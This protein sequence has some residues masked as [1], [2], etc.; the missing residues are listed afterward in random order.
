[1]PDN[2]RISAE[3][4]DADKQA[5]L[6]AIAL[7]RSKLPFLISLTPDERTTLP[8]LGEKTLAFE[9]KCRTYMTSHPNL[10]PSFVDAAEVEKDRTLRTPVVEIWREL[11]ALTQAVDDTVLLLGSE[12]YMAD[13]SFYQNSRQAAKMGVADAQTVYNDLKVRFPGANP[14]P[15]QPPT[16]PHP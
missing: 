2:N 1:M 14:T 6:D 5:V 10:L 8:K 3:L 15:A 9:D 16:P 12:I 11:S 13:L 4:I 7:V